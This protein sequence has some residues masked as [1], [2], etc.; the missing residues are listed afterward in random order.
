MSWMP[1]AAVILSF[2]EPRLERGKRPVF[3]R[4]YFKAAVYRLEKHFCF[5]R[6]GSPLVLPHIGLANSPAI[7]S[8]RATVT[9]SDL[10]ANF[11]RRRN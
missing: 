4:R 9:T 1:F 10:I 2:Y 3:L 8:D 6:D 11:R 5:N 7:G